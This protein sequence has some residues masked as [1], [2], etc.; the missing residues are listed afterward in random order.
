MMFKWIAKI[1]KA[2]IFGANSSDAEC[3]ENCPH[4]GYYCM[5]NTIYCT[6]PI[7]EDL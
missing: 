6:P 5:D 2:Y 7:L 1:F 4:C 3:F